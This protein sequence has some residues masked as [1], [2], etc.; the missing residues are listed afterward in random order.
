VDKRKKYRQRPPLIPVFW[1]APPAEAFAS[2]SV[3]VLRTKAFAFRSSFFSASG[4]GV[5][6]FYRAMRRHP[7]FRP[8]RSGAEKSPDDR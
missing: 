8:E 3:F 7:S 2:F 5:R 6:L 4:E 1:G